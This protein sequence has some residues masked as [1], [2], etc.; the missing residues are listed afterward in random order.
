MKEKILKAL[1][2]RCAFGLYG[3][4]LSFLMTLQ[5]VGL[6]NLS[7]AWAMGLAVAVGF[8][9]A[10]AAYKYVTGAGWAWR[11]ALPWVIGGVAGTVIGYLV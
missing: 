8:G 1:G 3:A 7:T 2:S 6:G 10:A 4:V 5:E 9:L 11:N